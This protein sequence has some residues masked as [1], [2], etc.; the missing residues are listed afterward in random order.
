MSFKIRSL[1]TVYE[2]YSKLMKAEVEAPDGS[3]FMREIEH[4][5]HAVAVLPYDPERR[6]ALLV[7]LPRP[8]VTWAGGP[9]EM[10]E[11]PAGM[12]DGDEDPA[13]AARREAM[14]ET[15]VRLS[16]LDLLAAVW[17]S[18]GVSSERVHLFLGAYTQKDRVA[19]G[20]G[21]EEEQEHITVLE[22]PL[23]ELWRWATGGELHDM[24]TLA[25]TYALRVRRP[26]LFES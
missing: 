25:L 13:D 24:K 1:E 16:D 3:T 9:A 23:A 2:G 12:L 21:V 22:T 15:G 26:E 10:I 8:P 4:H 14:E 17:A 7:R 6:C 19:E 20:G 11:A 5:G 18:G